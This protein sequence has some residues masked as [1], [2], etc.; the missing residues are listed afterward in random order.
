M[1]E[2]PLTKAARDKL[3]KAHTTAV[4]RYREALL[5]DDEAAK[6]QRL[7]LERRFRLSAAEVTMSFVGGQRRLERRGRGDVY[8]QVMMTGLLLLHPCW[9]DAH[10][11]EP[12][13]HGDR[14]AD[15]LSG[16]R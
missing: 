2:R 12:E 10:A 11:G 1:I 14:A 5:E 15:D 4:D 13:S 8:Q 7:E 6:R 16:G 9:R 3:L